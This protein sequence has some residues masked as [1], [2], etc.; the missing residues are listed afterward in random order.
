MWKLKNIEAENLCAFRHLSYTLQQGVTT[1]IFGDN[2]DN[3]SQQSNGAG[4][5]AL[6]ECIAV[7]ITGSPLRKIR[8]EEI[9]NDAAEECRIELRLT[10]DFSGEELSVAR[11][12][13]R[14]GASTVACMLWRDGKEAETDEAVQPS[15]DAYNWYIL[16][17]LGI[18]RDELLNNFILSKYRYADFLSSS[19]KEKKEIIN[20]FSNGILVD[21]A[22]ARVEEDIDPLSDEQ[23]RINLELAG[24][25]GRIGMLQEQID[26][27]TAAREERGRTREARIAEL[28]AAIDAKREQIRVHKEEMAGIGS[29]M[30]KVRQ[31][32]EALQELESSDT[33]LEECL[34]AIETFMPLFPD[35][36]RTDWNRAVR[37]KKENMEVARA[38]LTNLD[39]AVK[40]AEETLAKKHTAWE[41]FKADYAGFRSLYKDKT[42]DFQS[43]LLDIDKQLRDLA[44]RLDDLRRKRRTISAGIDELSNKL[45]GKIACPACGHEFLVA[46]PG[47]DIEAGTKD[48]RMRQQQLSE[49]NGRI[50]A[51]ERQTEEVEMR[52]SRIRTESRTLESDR[53]GWEQRLS[54]HE[55]A[56]R[57][58]TDKVESAEH[59]RKRTHAEIAALQDEVDGIRRKVFDEVFGFIDER[60]AALGREKR[61]TEEDIRAAVCAVET[62][63]DTIRE[64]N[65]ATTT[66]LPRSLRATM[67][68]EKQRSMETARR[69][70]EVDDR[71]RDL[72]VQRERFVQFKTYLA[73]TKIEA[74][75]RITNEFLI[76]IG[77]D[78]RIRFDGYTVLKSGKVREKISISL[79]RDG[80]DCGS[81]GKFSAGEAARVNLATILAMQKLVNANCDDGKGLDLLVLDEILE[82]VDE[83]GLAS[84]FEALNAL[85]GTVLVVSHGN[86]AEGYPHKLVI[87]KE[88]GES[89]IGE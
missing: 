11:R 20:R 2:R 72:E 30:E 3:E 23:Q 61:K 28:E 15:V 13:P 78:I 17:K 31:A 71:V 16:D 6:L 46:H 14:K 86:V 52:Q 9:I 65:E 53:H 57:G 10:N 63:Q 5:S 49:I 40:Q 39:A 67:Q 50:E 48:L 81:F 32:D 74:L 37:L 24:I 88:H 66:D 56:V 79:L 54:E 22:I 21:E 87:T 1:L 80:V 68:Q 7:G 76:A 19:D 43:R 25:D 36:R 47:F 85:G 18:T 89:R 33:P 35:A 51:G 44:G 41:R 38:S 59:Q 82:A 60:N 26:R 42:A 8:S 70:F 4:K 62:L 84:M 75:S 45:A 64:V 27:E 55:R 69:K 12:I 73:N 34:K 58:A 77:S 29:A 83:A